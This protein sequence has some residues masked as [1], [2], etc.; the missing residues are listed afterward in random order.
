[1]PHNDHRPTARLLEL[2]INLRKTF[3]TLFVSLCANKALAAEPQ[4]S[5]YPA[6]LRFVGAGEYY[7]GQFVG[8]VNATGTL[9]ID[10]GS[11]RAYFYP[12]AT[13]IRNLPNVIRG[14]HPRNA[15]VIF[16]GNG[17]KVLDHAL[18]KQALTR[19]LAANQT[20]FR[21]AAIVSLK[22]PRTRIACDRREYQAELASLTLQKTSAI[23]VALPSQDCDSLP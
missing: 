14:D 21:S 5:P 12:D 20:V 4:F 9:L 7:D 15:D 19:L 8:H 6:S 10:F 2:R 1:L 3:L 16:V 13:S 11:N 22:N 18:G 23:M 17:K